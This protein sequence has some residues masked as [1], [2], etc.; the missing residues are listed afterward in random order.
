MRAE[1]ITAIREDL[2]PNLI[3]FNYLDSE[4]QNRVTLEDIS[5]GFDIAGAELLLE[6]SQAV[7]DM[8][9]KFKEADLDSKGSLNFSQF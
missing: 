4:R 7:Q 1:A 5:K 6:D 8:V 9:A 2:C 3:L